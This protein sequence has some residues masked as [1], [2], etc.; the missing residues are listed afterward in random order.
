MEVVEVGGSDLELLEHNMD[1]NGQKR[2][3][4]SRETPSMKKKIDAEPQD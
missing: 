3:N 1:V 4:S 2:P